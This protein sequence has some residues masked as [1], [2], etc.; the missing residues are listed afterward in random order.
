MGNSSG[1]DYLSKLFF[2]L[3]KFS[4]IGL[5]LTGSFA[6]FTKPAE[7]LGSIP[8]VLIGIAVGILLTLIF[9]IVGYIFSKTKES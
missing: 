4:F 3:A 6:L 9:G 1:R 2:E 8:K 7:E 5:T